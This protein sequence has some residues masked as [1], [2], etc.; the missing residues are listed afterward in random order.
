MF[1][2]FKKLLCI[3][4]NELCLQIGNTEFSQYLF[5]LMLILTQWCLLSCNC[6]ADSDL[7]NRIMYYIKKC[8]SLCFEAFQTCDVILFILPTSS[9][10]ALQN[11]FF[12]AF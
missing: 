6:Y 2:T 1:C 8:V 3:K 4:T 10:G 11:K 12:K 7:C 9:F 5:F